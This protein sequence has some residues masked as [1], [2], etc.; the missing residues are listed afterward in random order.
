MRGRKRKLPWWLLEI[1][2]FFYLQMR[3]TSTSF[4]SFKIQTLPQNKIKWILL[5]HKACFYSV[6]TWKWLVPQVGT[7]WLL[8]RRWWWFSCSVMSYSCDP[9]DCSL[10]GSSVHGISQA[11]ILEWA[12]IFFSRRSF[13]LRGQTASPALQ[14]NSLPLSHL[15]SPQSS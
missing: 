6:I 5:S 10:T 1:S 15:G 11:R 13:W 2:L 3:N 9:V 14:A 8:F 4:E 12:T 7:N